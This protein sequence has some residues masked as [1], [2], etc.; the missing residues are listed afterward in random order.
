MRT[1]RS[2][3]RALVPRSSLGIKLFLVTFGIAGS[4]LL[5]VPTLGDEPDREYVPTCDGAR[6]E[7]G[8]VCT[9]MGTGTDIE[10][11]DYH[12]LVAAH[13]RRTRLERQVT[14]GAF[15]AGVPVAVVFGVLGVLVERRDRRP[16]RS[17]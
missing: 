6:M 9:V 12:D 11:H 4:L 13:E 16:D 17:A 15:A 8:D 10:S 3:G 1:V 14:I 2:A 5:L 7:P